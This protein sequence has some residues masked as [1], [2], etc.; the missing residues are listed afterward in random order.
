MKVVATISG[1]IDSPVAAYLMLK[2]G[3]DVVAF[4]MDNTPFI[5]D[6]AR[7]KTTMVVTRLEEVT[8]S[9]IKFYIAPHGPNLAAFSQH[10]SPNLTCLLCKRMIMRIGEK[11][12]KKEG[13]QAL[14]TGDSLGQVAS[15]TLQNLVVTSN[16]V[17]IPIL[18][19]LIG[20]DKL[21]I[22]RIAEEIGTYPISCLSAGDCK[23]VPQR[24]ATSAILERVSEQEEGGFIDLDELVDRT[25]EGLAL[26]DERERY[27]G[28]L[29]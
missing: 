11:I 1:G 29:A 25:L 23:A 19:P 4:H 24:P 10:C 21:E 14:V 16:A 5:G 20:L 9:S 17:S 26:H 15:Q 7:Q 18:R 6:R 22:T 8:G 28:T 2:R 12:A 3:V 27:T 13:A